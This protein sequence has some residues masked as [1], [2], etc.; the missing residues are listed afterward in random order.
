MSFLFGNE[1]AGVM[2]N[3]SILFNNFHHKYD[4]Y[5]TQLSDI[6]NELINYKTLFKD[7]VVL[8]NCNDSLSGNFYKFFS[9]YFNL[10]G[11]KK[12]IVTEYNSLFTTEESVYAHIVKKDNVHTQR[13]LK[14]DIGYSVG[15]FR[16]EDCIKLLK[17]AD[18][19]VT[20]PPISLLREH[21]FQLVDY[22][23]QFL[24]LGHFG[25][26]MNPRVCSFFKDGKVHFGFNKPRCFLNPEDD[27]V[28]RINNLPMRWI[29]NFAVD[30][31]YENLVFEKKYNPKEYPKYSNVNAIHVSH[32]IDIPYDYNGI[33]G[34]PVTFFDIFNPK[35]FEILDN[36]YYGF[37]G[38]ANFF[39]PVLNGKTL[40]PRL[41]IRRRK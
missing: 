32:P 18:I 34:V 30:K 3:S 16:S 40:P 13:K 41:L 28:V 10:L 15:D 6:Q 21:L 9:S 4:D 12:L 2:R 20:F 23:K 5:C 8:C 26:V 37:G 24:I 31:K 36:S 19:V 22:G 33:M 27:K 29:T 35:D 25:V 39:R 11:L 7:K 17:S 14:Y 1:R 38:R